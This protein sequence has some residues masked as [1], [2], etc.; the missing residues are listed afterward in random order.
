[1]GLRSAYG[2]GGRVEEG[3]TARAAGGAKARVDGGVAVE[4]RAASELLFIHLP[5]PHGHWR[6]G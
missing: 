4:V 3:E 1:M 6:L 2:V 5:C